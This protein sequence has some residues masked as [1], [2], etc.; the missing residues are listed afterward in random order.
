MEIHSAILSG[1]EN[2]QFK[3]SWKDAVSDHLLLIFQMIF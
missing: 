3:E 2:G 1:G